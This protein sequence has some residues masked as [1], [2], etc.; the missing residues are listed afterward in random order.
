MAN[1]EEI[2]QELRTIGGETGTGA[3]SQQIQGAA[4]AGATATG[5]PVQIGGVYNP[6]GISLSNGSIWPIQFDANGN[7]KT[8]L[9]TQLAGEDLTND[10]FKVEQ[11][12]SNIYLTLASLTL[13]KSGAGFIN[14]ITFGHGSNPTLTIYDNTAGSGSITQV[15]NAGVPAGSYVLD[16][17]H[18][19]GIAAVFAAPGNA[20]AV[21]VGYR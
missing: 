10:V 12:F 14:R 20:I 21:S 5:S 13:V 4:A 19:T 9:G 16:V 7:I 1:Q 17:S 2:L 8:T 18:A 3:S 6:S 15:F 11:R